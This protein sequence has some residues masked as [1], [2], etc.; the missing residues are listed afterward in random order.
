MKPFVPLFCGVLLLLCAALMVS[1]PSVLGAAAPGPVASQAMTAGAWQVDLSCGS[2]A[3]TLNAVDMISATDGWAV[4]DEGTILHWNGV[5]WQQVSSP[6][7][8]S[9]KGVDMISASD[10][11]AVGDEGTILHWS[12][13][14]WQ[15]APTPAY[16]QL[17]SVAMVS[18]TD[19]W[20]VGFRPDRYGLGWNYVLRWD[21][22]SWQVHDVSW[23]YG[24]KPMS[25]SMSGADYGWMATF[26]FYDAPMLRHWTGTSWEFVES[27]IAAN[28]VAANAQY[29]GW[30]VGEGFVNLESLQQWPTVPASSLNGAALVAQNDAWA[31][32]E[33]GVIYHWTGA[34]WQSTASPTLQSLKSV[35]MT[36]ASNGWAVGAGGVILHYVGA[37]PAG[38]T[39]TSTPTSRCRVTPTP[40]PPYNGTPPASGLIQRQVGHCMDDAYVVL[41]STTDLW[42]DRNYVRMGGI[43]GTAVPYVGYVDGL[44]FRDVRIPRGAQITSARLTLLPYGFQTGQ[45]IVVE[46]AGEASGQAADF[47]PANPWPNVRP[48]TTARV[49]WLI[50]GTVTQTTASPELAPIVQEIV[51]QSTWKAGNNLALLID[52]VI[53]G[54]HFINWMTYDSGATNSA[55]LDVRYVMPAVTPT[56]T[57]T[58]TATAM[59]TATPTE[60]ATPI[61]PVPGLSVRGHVRLG[62]ALGS[63]IPG[64]SV[65]VFLSAY[66][67]PVISATTNAEGYYATD[68]IYLPGDETISVRPVLAGY[69][70]DPP[71]YTWWHPVGAEEA[72]RDFVA[73]SSLPTVTP[74]PTRT[75]TQSPTETTT[76]TPPPT[77][78]MTPSPTVTCTVTRKVWLPLLWQSAAGQT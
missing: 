47:N 14:V 32:G 1:A 74:T 4:G 44:L 78:S 54:V 50:T 18:H 77:P 53:S 46:V 20:A 7:T 63:G 65:Q 25:V 41:G 17:R 67:W 40:L 39:R 37:P 13:N 6:T 31:V 11:W 36:S 72:V 56:P 57:A 55:R 12:G 60:T 34:D 73:F 66:A 62:S 16:T 23:D 59:P 22:A 58:L 48:R 27:P 68:L 70:F 28:A 76:P 9:L 52:P 69:T 38:G 15:E 42:N 5:R 30:A 64:V 26:D 10:G 19:G 21:G 33:N 43:T 61:P 24:L 49:P 35:A 45:P 3:A 2:C 51:K 8:A 29:G 71:Q 75:A